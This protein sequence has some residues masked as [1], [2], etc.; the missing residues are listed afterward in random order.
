MPNTHSPF[1]VSRAVDACELLQ[2][3]APDLLDNQVLV[4]SGRWQVVGIFVRCTACGYS[5]K[6]SAG[7]QPFPH[8]AACRAPSKGEDFPWRELAAIL[9]NLPT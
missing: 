1:G 9:G 8:A 4:Y 2:Q 5:Q 6:A 3:P 7:A